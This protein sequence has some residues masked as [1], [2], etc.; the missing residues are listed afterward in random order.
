[1]FYTVFSSTVLYCTVY[2][3]VT[4]QHI[5]YCFEQFCAVQCCSVLHCSVLYC[6]KCTLHAYSTF[7][8]CSVLHS[9]VMCFTALFSSY[10]T[11]YTVQNCIDDTLLMIYRSY[12][13]ILV[14]CTV[15][16]RVQYRIT[17]RYK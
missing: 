1:M 8:F 9:T 17:Q 4:V 11:L 12:T 2:S 3:T 14:S 16:L 5:M 10:S 15:H 6:F 13:R 7:M